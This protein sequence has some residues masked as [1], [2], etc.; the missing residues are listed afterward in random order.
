MGLLLI[1]SVCKTKT[2]SHYNVSDTLTLLST[3]S[4]YSDVV[5][6]QATIYIKWQ[7]QVCCIV[8][9]MY[10]LAASYHMPAYVNTMKTSS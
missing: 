2:I 8:A 6:L 10:C 5:V 3:S 7:D 1:V 9:N 4:S